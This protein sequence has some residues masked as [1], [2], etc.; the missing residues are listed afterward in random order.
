MTPGF[1][2]KRTRPPSTTST[3][4]I[5]AAPRD[6]CT[7]IAHANKSSVSA[8]S[9][10]GSSGSGACAFGACGP[11]PDPSGVA[12]LRVTY[13]DPELVDQLAQ[14][15]IARIAGPAGKVKRQYVLKPWRHYPH[16][17]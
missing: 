8:S 3:S 2:N 1:L 5:A 10:T 4:S 7:A 11:V 9:S 13:T 6:R 16:A 15:W 14:S 12:A 17:T